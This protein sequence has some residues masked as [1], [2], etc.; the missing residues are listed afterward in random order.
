[1]A[2]E[3]SGGQRSRFI[4]QIQ[5]SFDLALALL[6]ATMDQGS[7]LKMVIF[8]TISPYLSGILCVNT[9]VKCHIGSSLF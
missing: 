3:G 9:F 5:H 4:Q 2:S 7:S 6:Y 8:L 1:M